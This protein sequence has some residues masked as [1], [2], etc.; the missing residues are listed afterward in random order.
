MLHSWRPMSIYCWDIHI[1]STP[2][3]KSKE[4][5]CLVEA[6][7]SSDLL[8]ALIILASPSAQVAQSRS[9]SLFHWPIIVYLPFGSAARKSSTLH[10]YVRGRGQVSSREPEQDPPQKY[11]LQSQ[12][13]FF[14]QH[15]TVSHCLPTLYSFAYPLLPDSSLSAPPKLY[16][17][18]FYSNRLLAYFYYINN[19]S[20]Y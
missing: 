15:G 16:V 5:V 10:D 3:S 14:S 12:G 20:L 4:N 1:K 11:I 7:R 6:V 17:Y 18:K 2:P 13:R 9:C 19:Y 8:I